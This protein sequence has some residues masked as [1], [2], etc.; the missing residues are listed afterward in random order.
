MIQKLIKRV[1]LLLFSLFSANA[2]FSQQADTVHKTKFEPAFDFDQRFNYMQNRWANVWGYREGVI[3]KGKYKVGIG[4][5]YMNENVTEL[6]IPKDINPNYPVSQNQQLYYGTVY[7]E[8]FLF[9]HEY[10]E[11]SLVF[12]AGYGRTVNTFKDADD[13]VVYD[14]YNRYFVPVGAGVSIN[15]K[16]P[17]LFGWHALRW[18][19]INICGGYRSS[20]AQ[21]DPVHNYNG[22]YWSISTAIFL[23]RMFEDIFLKKHKSTD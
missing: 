15:L 6:P 22:A 8:P 3:I 21:G 5:Y 1:V 11:A 23:D 19:G 9:R 10:L 18:F 20:I 4:E 12:E 14:N 13:G 7:F 16:F 17:A 2:M